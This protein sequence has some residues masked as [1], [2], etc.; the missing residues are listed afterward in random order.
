M[1][2]DEHVDEDWSRRERDPVS[3]SPTVGAKY[4]GGFNDISINDGKDLWDKAAMAFRQDWAQTREEHAMY[5]GSGPSLW[6]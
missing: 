5:P 3:A 4:R 6:R 2:G 1:A